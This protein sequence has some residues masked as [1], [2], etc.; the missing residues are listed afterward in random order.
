[1]IWIFKFVITSILLFILIW[2]GILNSHTVEFYLFPNFLN[3]KNFDFLQYPLYMIITFSVLFGF[4]LGCV[5]ENNRSNKIRKSLKKKI[6]ELN[7]SD[8]E[9][10]RIKKKLNENNEDILSLLE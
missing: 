3:F 1:M 7:K 2:F 9:L 8:I 10:Q 6:N 4:I 5:L